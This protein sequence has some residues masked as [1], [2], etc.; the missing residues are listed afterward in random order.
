MDNKIFENLKDT[1]VLFVEDDENLKNIVKSLIAPYINEIYTAG[2]GEEGLELFN[3][4]KIDL[5]ISDIN[6]AH[7]SGISMAQEIRKIDPAVPIIFITAYD[8]DENL[9]NSISLKSSGFL[10]K[11]FDRRQLMIS[12]LMAITNS[13]NLA[14][15][16][17]D[18]KNGFIYDMN[19]RILY[20]DGDVVVLTRTEQ[21][22]LYLLIKNIGRVV[23]FDAIESYVWNEKFASLDTI[24]NFINRIRSK[25]YPEL[26]KN[27]SGIGYKIDID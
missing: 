22:F 4:N 19:A 2:N 9:Y 25:I 3:A 27:I 5:I 11:P 20:K 1:N 17:I 21:R 7:M 16:T 14:K 12:M 8:T 13:Q 23:S 26:I 18:L 15:N 24:R 10:K 6:M